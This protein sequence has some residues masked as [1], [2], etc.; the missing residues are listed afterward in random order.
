ML[1]GRCIEQTGDETTEL[2]D[3]QLEIE[4]PDRPLVG[5]DEGTN[6]N[7]QSGWQPTQM[8]VRPRRNTA[9][10]RCERHMSTIILAFAKQ[11]QRSQT[12]R[13]SNSPEVHRPGGHEETLQRANA[14]VF[15]PSNLQLAGL[16]CNPV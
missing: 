1:H 15:Q 14:C 12:W 16:M 5:R 4:T 7:E 9:T 10:N 13:G 11:Q 6:I 8:L 3:G 2:A